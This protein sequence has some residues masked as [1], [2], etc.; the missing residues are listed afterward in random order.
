MVL[1]II[2]I[3]TVFVWAV[4]GYRKGFVKQAFALLGVVGVAFLSVP[5]AEVIETILSKDMAMMITSRFLKGALLAGCGAVIYIFCYVVG[6]FVHNTLVNG[7]S[8]AESTNHV[9]G[10]TLGVIESSLGL[11]FFLSLVSMVQDRVK[12]YAPAAYE[13]FDESKCY[14]IAQENNLLKNSEFFTKYRQK[15]EEA[16]K[17]GDAP[18]DVETNKEAETVAPE[19]P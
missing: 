2:C 5:L 15:S 19:Q 3:A 1:D 7:I 8:V 13:F 6:R 10:S 11:F 12:E 18:T 14:H 4:F 16:P 17:E 9:L